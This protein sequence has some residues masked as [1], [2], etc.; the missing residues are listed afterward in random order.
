MKLVEKV[1]W[2]IELNWILIALAVGA[3]VSLIFI[4]PAMELNFTMPA[5]A[6]R[7][8]IVVAVFI[9]VLVGGLLLERKISKR[10]QNKL[11]GGEKS[12]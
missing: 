3:I 2:I 4:G 9:A 5:I 10:F 8:G 11:K 12:L 6:I 7:I 1:K